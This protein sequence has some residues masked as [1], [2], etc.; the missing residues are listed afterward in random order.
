MTQRTD[1]VDTVFVDYAKQ[2]N[3]IYPD[4]KVEFE[5]LRDYTGEI[6]IRMN[7]T[8]YGDVLLIPDAITLDKL[9]DYFEPMGTVADLDS[10]Y[11]FIAA[12]KVYQGNVYGVSITGNFQGIACNKNVFDAAG[13]TSNPKTADEFIAAMQ[14]IKDKTGAIPVYTNYA[15]GWHTHLALLI[16]LLEEGTRPAFWATHARLKQEYTK[17]LPPT[18]AS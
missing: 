4:V 17:L 9:S 12:G 8:D 7:T 13:I 10:K 1:I 11:N 15:A 6:Q 3:E 2:F 18:S 5:A 14:L 16:A